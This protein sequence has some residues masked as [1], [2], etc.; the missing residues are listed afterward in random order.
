[1]RCEPPGLRARALAR[2]LRRFEAPG[3]DTVRGD[4]LAV[5]WAEACGANVLDVDGNR[6]LDLTSGFGVAAIGHRHPRVLSAIAEQGGRLLHGLG[7]VAAHPARVEL[8]GR[9]VGLAPFP[10]R[11]YFAV[12]GSDAV[13]IALKTAMLATERPGVLAFSPSYHGLS[14]GALAV[15]SRPAFRDPFAARLGAWVVR[16]PFGCAEPELEQALRQ[17]AGRLGACLVEPIVGRE[18]VLLPPAGWLSRLGALCAEHGLVRIADEVFTGFGRAGELFV[19]ETDGYE[20]DLLCL[21]KALG[22]GLPIAVVLGR[23]A[24]L[25]HWPGSGEALHTATFLAHPLACAAALA[26]LEVLEQ[27]DLFARSRRLG[28]HAGARLRSLSVPVRGRGLLWGIEAD[29]PEVAHRWADHALRSGVIALAGGHRG[30]V[31]QIVPPLTITEEQ[32]DC[33]L[34]VIEQVVGS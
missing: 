2:D 10:A 22:G 23:A 17:G 21:G 28:E 3:V 11:V 4:E 25:E 34:D 5:P 8:A 9:L 18:G 30:T 6:Y 20:P 1:M 14:L 15:S 27:E 31:L 16:L 13:E 7:D 32:L 26:S 19:S 24:L 33:A 29:R 12:S